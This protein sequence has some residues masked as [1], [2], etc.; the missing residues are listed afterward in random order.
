MRHMP[1]LLLPRAE[2]WTI[3]FTV[4]LPNALTAASGPGFR[5][6]AAV[7]PGVEPY[8]KPEDFGDLKE[9]GIVGFVSHFENGGYKFRIF[10][11]GESLLAENQMNYLSYQLEKNDESLGRYVT[12]SQVYTGGDGAN[13]PAG[14][15][16]RDFYPGRYLGH[17]EGTL[18]QISFG[19]LG[20]I[21]EQ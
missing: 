3:R 12:L 20:D 1:L 5:T 7:L 9:L 19:T 6:Q 10:W 21:S 18:A 13:A 16:Y 2:M 11:Q 8:G 4:G 15:F 17:A 14:V